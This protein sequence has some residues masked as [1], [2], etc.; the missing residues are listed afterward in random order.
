ME[1]CKLGFIKEKIGEDK[2]L[3]KYKD[4]DKLTNREM[5]I[6]AFESVL[7]NI[8]NDN[9]F[10]LKKEDNLIKIRAFNKNNNN[11]ISI[12]ITDGVAPTNAKNILSPT[13]RRKAIL[14]ELDI[15]PEITQ[16]QLAK[17]FMVSQKTISNDLVI[18][19]N[20]KDMIKKY[21]VMEVSI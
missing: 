21:V 1:N 19:N 3:D 4:G 7:E 16:N 15:N 10:Y 11:K 6:M 9:E 17:L 18:L 2:M 8:D 13:N 14:E 12:V 20:N 5:V